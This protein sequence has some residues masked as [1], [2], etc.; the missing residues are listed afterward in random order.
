MSFD[1]HF[2]PCR[3]DGTTERRKNPFTGQLQDCPRNLPLSKSEVDAVLGV[4]KMAGARAS[5]DDYQFRSA[6]GASVEIF[7]TNLANGCMFAIRGAGITPLLAQLLF[8]VMVAGNWVI[9]GTGGE[10]VVIAPNDKAVKTAPTDF[11][12]IV[13]ASSGKEVA[14]LLSGGFG[15]W[16]EYRA[17]VVGGAQ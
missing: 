17:Q 3:F 9:M 15:A 11:G 2:Q 14:T 13:V 16:E 8:D 1:V 6:D 7:A 10:D 4:F 5:G 12:Q